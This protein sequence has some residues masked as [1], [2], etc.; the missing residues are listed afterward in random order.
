MSSF[1]SGQRQSYFLLKYFQRHFRQ[2]AVA[3]VGKHLETPG[4]ENVKG[5]KYETMRAKQLKEGQYPTLQ[6]GYRE[7]HSAKRRRPQH[8]DQVAQWNDNGNLTDSPLG[9]NW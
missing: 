8:W 2:S 7:D 3:L 6:K 1:P 4:V 5:R 9:E